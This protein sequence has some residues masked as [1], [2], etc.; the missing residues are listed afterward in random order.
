MPESGGHGAAALQGAHGQ[1]QPGDDAPCLGHFR[2]AH[3]FEI[4]RAQPFLARHGQCRVD[5]DLGALVLAVRALGQVPVHPVQ[6]RLGGAFFRRLDRAFLGHA[7]NGGQ[8]HRHHVLDIARVAPIEPEDLVEGG[9]VLGAADETG[10]QHMVEIG[11]LV[12]ACRFD[13]AHRV[14]HAPRPRLQPS[15]P[16]RPREMGDIG[17][18][19]RV[20]WQLKRDLFGHVASI[21]RAP[22]LRRGPFT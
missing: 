5:L 7:A 22:A 8:H 21:E 20:I 18:K 17:G 16:E 19:L 10:L 1:C 12:K 2:V 14:Q 9:A 13:R 11:P 15:R 6:Q 4:K 3:L